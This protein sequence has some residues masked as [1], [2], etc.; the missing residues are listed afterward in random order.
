M[1]VE[2][3]FSD[4]GR[5]VTFAVSNAASFGRE[6]EELGLATKVY[7]DKPLVVGRDEKGRTYVM[8]SE[9]S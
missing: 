4:A 9:F 7:G 2:K 5:N 6:L 1:K 3:K 8:E